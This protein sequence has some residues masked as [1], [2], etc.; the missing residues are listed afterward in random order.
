VGLA[1][2]YCFRDVLQDSASYLASGVFAALF[3]LFDAW[4]CHTRIESG[5]RAILRRRVSYFT[6]GAVAIW[7]AAISAWG[8]RFDSAWTPIALLAS[9]VLL[10]A[11]VYRLRIREFVVIGQLPALL[12]IA[13]TMGLAFHT[14]EFSWPILCAL[15][16]GLLLAHW[17]QWQGK[18]FTSCCPEGG[19]HRQLLLCWEAIFSAG[20][21]LNLF[22]WIFAGIEVGEEWLL[23]GPAMA[24]GLGIY[25]MITRARVV[26]VLSQIFLWIGCLAMM[27]M[28]LGWGGDGALRALVPIFTLCLVNLAMPLAASRVAELPEGWGQAIKKMQSLYRF[29]AAMLG[30]LWIDQCVA[31]DWHVF[32][33]AAVGGLLLLANCWRPSEDWFW[34]S[35]LFLGVGGGFLLLEFGDRVAH[36]QALVALLMLLGVQQLARRFERLSIPDLAHHALISGAGIAIF[37]WLTVTVSNVAQSTEGQ[38]VRSIAWAVLAV[39]YFSLG[40]GLKERWYRLMGLCTLGIALLSLFPIIWQM[41]TEMK[42]ASF[43][44]IGLI[45]VGLGYIYNHNKETI[46]KLL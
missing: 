11:S 6:G 30:M 20:F 18:A 7:V 5:E 24:V 39:I 10:T 40:L 42:I 2:V 35:A 38:G 36:W 29:L 23:L 1:A 8:G 19:D 22:A 46:K 34:L 31:D 41:S 33:L 27:A 17:W 28:D 37:L 3:L 44:V 16:I 9:T 15:V 26:A 25:G 43:F 13:W 14:P 45:F 4:L 12:G 32:A 21:V